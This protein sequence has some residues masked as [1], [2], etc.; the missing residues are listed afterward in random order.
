MARFY[1][2][3]VIGVDPLPLTDYFTKFAIQAKFQDKHKTW[4]ISFNEHAHGLTI[5]HVSRQSAA[6]HAGLSYDDTIIAI[7][8]LKATSALLN[9]L[10]KHQNTT[11]SPLTVHAFR[12]DELLSFTINNQNHTPNS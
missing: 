9:R 5:T 1:H 11:G 10:V 3:Y 8:G 12:R 2:R 6:S 7:D 4:G